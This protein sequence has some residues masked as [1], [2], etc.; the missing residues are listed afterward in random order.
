[1]TEAERP[2][3]KGRAPRE[4]KDRPL[5][6][7]QILFVE[8]YLIDFN[9]KAAAIKA[10]YKPKAA[11]A[12]A[13]DL[14]TR[15]NIQA[16]FQKRFQKKLA[17]I[18]LTEESVLNEI[19]RLSF[20]DA[21]KLLGPNGEPLPTQEID[22][23]TAACIAG[24]EVFEEYRGEGEERVFVGYTKKYKLSSKT[25]ALQMAGRYLKLFTDKHEVESKGGVLCVPVTAQTPEEWAKT[26][27]GANQ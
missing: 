20:S 16:E 7:Q 26:H 27:Q 4:L 1:M 2:K 25:E 22:D 13:S 19:A 14:L 9:G 17:K 11:S 3:R 15:P 6:P 21:R 12:Q 8:A 24:L 5:T 23:N 10:G 18:E